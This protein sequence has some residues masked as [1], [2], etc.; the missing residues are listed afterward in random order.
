[1]ADISPNK[2]VLRCYGQRKE[3]NK[4]FGV[5]LDFNLA[6]EAESIDAL[7]SKMREVVASYISVVMDT[8][9]KSS[10]PELFSR[11]APV[12]DW[13]IYYWIRTK[14]TIRNLPG[15]FTFKEFIPFHLPNS[16]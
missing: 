1:M 5:C 12:K 13:L 7:K 4:W 6:V 9:D 3:N 14:K 16:C 11:K 10:I 2:F 8:D 15:N